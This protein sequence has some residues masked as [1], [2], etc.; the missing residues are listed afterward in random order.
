MAGLF[1]QPNGKVDTD[2]AGIGERFYHIKDHLGSVR[3]TLD[4]IGT[5]VTAQ[6][7]APYG[8]SL[9]SYSD[10]YPNEK[11]RYNEKEKDTETG[12]LY[13]GARYYNPLL[14]IWNSTDPIYNKWSVKQLM[15]RR[16]FGHSPY[17]Y[18]KNSPVNK[19]DVQGYVDWDVVLTGT[20]QVSLGTVGFL[21]GVGVLMGSGAATTASGGTASP[22]TV[23]TAAMGVSQMVLGGSTAALG[24]VN[25]IRG[26][27][28][29]PEYDLLDEVGEELGIPQETVKML[30]LGLSLYDVKNVVKNLNSTETVQFFEAM[31]RY[32]NMTDSFKENLQKEVQEQIESEKE[33]ENKEDED[34][35]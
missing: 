31:A 32:Y 15:A 9:R 25:I 35:K 26:F 7:Y 28:D 23:P 8:N 27:K 3:I 30:K 34:N 6:D 29:M 21:A 22:I 11:Y 1:F 14:S 20:I 17:V 12:Y 24:T 16:M 18:V 4:E 13:Y 19:I 33:E 10:G 2:S 5:I